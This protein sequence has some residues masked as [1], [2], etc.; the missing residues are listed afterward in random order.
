M[1]WYKFL[2]FIYNYCINIYLVC[3]IYIG[4]IILLFIN[5]CYIKIN[6]NKICKVLNS[7][8]YR[9]IFFNFIDNC[10]IIRGYYIYF[11]CIFF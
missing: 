6:N 4:N 9:V 10:F 2:L 7:F 8:L 11:C 5:Y 1:F 3:I